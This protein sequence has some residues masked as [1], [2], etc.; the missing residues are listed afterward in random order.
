MPDWSYRTLFRPALFR[1]PAARARDLTLG[2]METLAR[3]PLGP[4]VIDL[5][6]HMRPPERLARTVSGITFPSPIGLGVGIDDNATALSALARLGFG[7]IELGPI[8]AEPVLPTRAIEL[9]SG[10]EA[11]WRSDPPANPGVEVIAR[12]LARQG[13]FVIPLV[14]RIGC[15]RDSTSENATGECRL[16]INRLASHAAVFSL[17]TARDSTMSTALRSSSR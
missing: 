15:R 7:F 11:I 6:G 1:L 16:I 3:L 12:R 13:Q 4:R 14:V 17:A 8:T 10:Q 2:L 9:R 5:L